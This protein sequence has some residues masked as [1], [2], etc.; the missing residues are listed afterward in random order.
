MTDTHAPDPGVPEPVA[1]LPP[2]DEMPD[3]DNLQIDLSQLP[4]LAHFA[5]AG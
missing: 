1:P 5:V 4:R 2:R 3:P